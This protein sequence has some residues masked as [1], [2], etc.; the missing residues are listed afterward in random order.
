MHIAPTGGAAGAGVSEA[1]LTPT[2]GQSGPVAGA[3]EP[4][5]SASTQQTVV[6]DTTVIRELAV[7][8][9]SK[10]TQILQP[11]AP[12]E[13]VA[14]VEHLV[15]ETVHAINTDRREWA[16]GRFIEAVTTDPSRVDELRSKPEFEPIQANVEQLLV[17]LTNVA[18]MDA[19]TKLGAAEQVLE[20]AGWQKLP[21]WE[22]APQALLQIGH[23]LLEAGGYAN[24]VRAADLATTL[25]TAYWGTNVIPPP[26]EISGAAT[27]RKEDTPLKRK[28]AG[29]ATLA[30]AYYGW[31]VLREKVPQQ[32][33]ALWRRA[34]LLVIM[35]AWFSVGL[36]G[37]AVSFL[38]KEIWPDSWIVPASN[39]GFRIWGLGF[40]AFVGFGFWAQ[41]R[42]PRG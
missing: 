32:V 2:T 36:V 37:G 4:S 7:A 31:Q 23:R 42:R 35:G 20:S 22:T 11:V 1:K 19:E 5:P 14:R 25:Q 38:A 10:L 24:Y 29:E 18:K 3:G 21:H 16:V 17:R 13:Q 8:D 30:L 34:P 15:N 12:P 40:L 41:V 9:L 28:S 26:L 33:E 6:N 27:I 39:F